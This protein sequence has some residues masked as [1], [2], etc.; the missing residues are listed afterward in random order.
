MHQPVYQLSPAGDY[1]M[2]WVRLHALK[3]YHD[4]VSILE[5]YENIKLNFNLVPVLLDALIDYGEKDLHDIHSR[6]TVMDVAKLSRDDKRFILNNFF[7]ANYE[8][9]ILP[10]ENYNK[11]Y[12]RY[13]NG[14]EDFSDQ[15]YSDLMALFNLAWIDNSHQKT[16]PELKKLVKKGSGYTRDDRIRIIEIQREIIR[17]VIP[18]Y[19]KFISDGKIEVTTSPYYHPILPVMLD[20]GKKIGI[21]L[22]DDARA[23]VKLALERVEKLLGKRPT[24]MWP[25]EHCISPKTL[26]LMSEQGIKWAI[27]DEGILSKSLNFEFVRDF[28]GYMEDPYHLLKTYKTGSMRLV[29]RDSVIPNFISFEYYNHDPAKAAN[30]LYD[31]IK[32]VQ[33]KLLS[34]PDENHLLT[35]AMDGENCW[36][37]YPDDGAV[38][39]ST[40]YN[41]IS[42]DPSL[43]TVLLSDYIE[44]DKPKPL[45]KVASGSWIN[46]NFDLWIGE[47]MK[48]LAWSYLKRVKEDFAG[49]VK[50][51]PNH[52]NIELAQRELFICEGS[53]WFW[54]YGEPNDSGKDNLFD[55]I[56]REHLKNTYAYLGLD[57][58]EF[59]EHPIAPMYGVVKPSRYPKATFT[60]EIT[61][62]GDNDWTDAGVI[63]IPDG[64]VLNEEKLFD[65]ISFGYDADN[66]YFRFFINPYAQNKKL[67][68]QMYVYT[69]AHKQQLS[70]VRLINKTDNILPLAKEK[71]HNELQITL[72][73]NEI[74]TRLVKAL[75]SNL[76]SLASEK[77]IAAAVD[78]VAEISLPFENLGIA[79]GETVEFLF[80]NATYGIR[81]SLI[82]NDMLL[83]IQR[84]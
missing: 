4:M 66:L 58:P 33:S 40:L 13:T 28:K 76:W 70:P 3:D 32:V 46:R 84:P 38:F 45:N 31:R 69:R 49:F 37:N 51:N 26:N 59:L 60:P 39:L 61:G 30:D 52:P 7:D 22:E 54:W 18:A 62:T 80:I 41:L 74:Y 12:Q 78:K 17:S 23:Q 47:P 83:S 65:K 15:E 77:G 25:S 9:M 14:A 20:S 8:Y 1:L 16:Y 68:H 36:E 27:S 10:S 34:S 73:N 82:P 75:G 43:E 24:G 79:P 21:N 67:I 57:V 55:Y 35:I 6:L 29:F 63:E 2:P 53:D 19:R 64:P 56:F 11:L 5:N 44:N 72:A 48:D 71:F 42:E 50:S 81:D